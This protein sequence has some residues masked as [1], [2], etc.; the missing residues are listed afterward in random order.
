MSRPHVL[1]LFVTV[2]FFL[3]NTL[4]RNPKYR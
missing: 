1:E 3:W 4:K 2:K